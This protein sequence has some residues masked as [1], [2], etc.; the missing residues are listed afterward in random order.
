[1]LR[2]RGLRVVAPA[3]RP[4]RARERVVRG[5][6]LGEERD[7]PLQV[8]DRL[9][10]APLARGDGAE[11]EVHRRRARGICQFGESCAALVHLPCVQQRF[12]QLQLRGQVRR[13]EPQGLPQR[14]DRKIGAREPLQDERLQVVP[15][16]RGRSKRLRAPVRA[17]G[18]FPLLPGVEHASEAARTAGVGRLRF[19]RRKCGRNGAARRRRI[20]VERQARQRR[21]GRLERDRHAEQQSKGHGKTA[22]RI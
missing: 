18:G 5:A 14:V 4:I 6:E 3:H 7:R 21:R 11:S 8:V 16:V 13:G 17:P 1:V 2:E 19:R 15:F 12:G 20:G 22:Y 9:G 10:L